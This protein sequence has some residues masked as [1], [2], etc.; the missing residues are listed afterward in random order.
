MSNHPPAFLGPTGDRLKE[1]QKFTVLLFDGH[2]SVANPDHTLTA[3]KIDNIKW[4]SW[5]G[6]ISGVL[7]LFATSPNARSQSSPV[8]TVT[9][10]ATNTLSI[11]VTNGVPGANYELWSTPVLGSPDFPWTTAAVGA[12]GQ[13]NFVV[14]IGPYPAGFYQ[15]IWDTNAIPLWEA[16]D[17]HNPAAG[18]LTVYIDSPTNGFNLTQ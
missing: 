11:T 15:A 17:P 9:P 12:P 14:N 5:A 8:L 3:M 18:I 2:S 7:I 16:A 4:K 6:I 13:T 1:T 10:T